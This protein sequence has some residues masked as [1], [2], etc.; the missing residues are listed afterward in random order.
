MKLIALI[1][2]HNDDY[3]LSLCLASIVDHFDLITVYDDWSTDATWAVAADFAHRY[4][5]VI[6]FTRGPGQVGWIEARNRLLVPVDDD[7]LLFWLDSDDVLCEYNAHLLREIAEGEQPI[8]RLQL[9]EMWGDLNHTTQRLRHYD[10]CHVFVNRRLAGEMLW[11][12]GAIA[13]PCY[14]L[15]DEHGP[16]TPRVR[17]I[18]PARG[19]GPLFFHIKGVKPDRRL[20]ERRFTRRW[21][22]RK[23]RLSDASDSSDRSDASDGSDYH[24]S[25]FTP[26]EIHRAA[27]KQLTHSKQDKLIPTYLSGALSGSAPRRPAVIEEELRKGQRFEMIYRDGLVVDRIDHGWT[28]P[29][30]TRPGADQTGAIQHMA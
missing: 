15:D 21:L 27:L 5:H 9:C 10:R 20:F 12:G 4:K 1:P 23:S 6:L 28:C 24:C 3:A 30:P 11:R 25:E 2:A 19:P 17:S 16:D 14:G 26:E 29:C 7:A 18:L 22:R 13:T 8:V